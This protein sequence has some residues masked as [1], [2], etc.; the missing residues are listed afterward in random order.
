MTSGGPIKPASA[1]AAPRAP[2]KRAPNTTEKFTTFGPGRNC[3][4]AKV[5]LNSC[6]VIQCLRSTIMRRAQ[7]S[8][9]PKPDIETTAKARNNS[10]SVGRS[11]ASAGGAAGCGMAIEN[12]L[13]HT[14]AT[15]HF[16][17]TLPRI[18]AFRLIVLMFMSSSDSPALA[19]PTRVLLNSDERIH[20][21][22]ARRKAP[23]A[24]VPAATF[25]GHLQ[26]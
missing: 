20:V 13:A 23:L 8:A 26:H 11:G 17:A 3:E 9:P 24:D 10:V 14:R 18:I 6:V 4:S 12:Y 21:A 1:T 15:R 19:P 7:G 16:A 2:P 25:R 5:S 22:R